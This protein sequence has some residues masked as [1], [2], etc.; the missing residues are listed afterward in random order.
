MFKQ[1]QSSEE[2]STIIGPSVRVEGTLNGVGNV[3]IEGELHGTLTT[4]KNV[5]IGQKAKIKANIQAH[6]VVISGRVD[7]SLS[8]NGHL[9]VKSSAK[10]SG[11]IITKTIAIESGATLNGKLVMGEGAAKHVIEKPKLNK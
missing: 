2:S 8:V 11:D 4:D 1:Q 9:D 10:I 6:N 5:T 3:V 7:G